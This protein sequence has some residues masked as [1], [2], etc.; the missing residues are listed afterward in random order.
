MSNEVKTPAPD[1]TPQ[2]RDEML[3]RILDVVK[4]D[5][6][7]RWIEVTSAIVLSLAT[8]ASAWC[9][10]Q[11]TLWS[12]VQTFRLAQ[13]NKADRDASEQ[14]TE[15]LQFKA[16]DAYMM[17]SYIEARGR[18]DEQLAV[19]LL[20]R[21]RPVMRKAV[22]AWLRTDPFHD[23]AA[24]KNPFKMAEYV[25]A[26][27]IEA[28]RLDAEAVRLMAAAQEA[29]HTSDKYVLLTVLFGMVLFLGGISGTF[30][31]RWL[32]RSLIILALVLFASIVLVLARMP[33]CVD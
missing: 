6:R 2:E 25:Q 29:N 11:S 7:K 15:A 19:F 26:E 17:I 1:L 5:Q 28:K 10:Y 16:V 20:E 21:F 13:A 24:P 3:Q 30:N 31:S 4:Q 12:G 23:P 14:R 18:K 27:E 8:M 22:D 9:A 33:L 32:R